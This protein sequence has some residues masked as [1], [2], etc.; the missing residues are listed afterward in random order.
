MAKCERVKVRAVWWWTSRKK[1]IQLYTCC[2]DLW[3]DVLIVGRSTF[4]CVDDSD[5][6]PTSWSICQVLIKFTNCWPREGE[7][8]LTWSDDHSLSFYFLYRNLNVDRSWFGAKKKV[9]T[10]WSPFWHHLA[11]TNLRDEFHRR[12]RRGGSPKEA[13]VPS[14]IAEPSLSG[15]NPLG[16]KSLAELP[17]SSNYSTVTLTVQQAEWI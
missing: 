8:R 17:S 4:T 5:E 16:L 11:G 9:Q 14:R 2:T 12:P 13:I 1:N 7:D 3:R 6:L 15:D 10:L